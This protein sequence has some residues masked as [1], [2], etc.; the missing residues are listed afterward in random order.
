ME[1]ALSDR[2]PPT[3]EGLTFEKVWA[4]F[5]ENERKWQEEKRENERKS[6]EI[7]E[8]MRGESE[9][10]SQEID[11]RFRKT[12]RIIGDLGNRFGELAEYLVAP[13]IHKRFNELG[14]HFDAVAPGGYVIRDGVNGKVIAEVDILLEN[15]KYIMAVEVKAKTRSKDIEHHIKR[16]EI[17]R[18]YRNKHHDTRIIQGAIA[19]A[20]FG[21]AEKQEAIEAG[22]YVL[23][24]SGDTVKMDIPDDFVPREW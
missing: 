15:E 7:W 22:F 1:A 6:Q 18:Q 11:R 9:R 10:R 19:G 14:Y 21:S 16:L 24:Q 3:G 13:N 20:I 4:M 2:P 12:N 8:K 17:L 23:E 5:Q